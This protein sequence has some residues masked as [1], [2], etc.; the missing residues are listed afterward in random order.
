MLKFKEKAEELETSFPIIGTKEFQRKKLKKAN[1]TE[2]KWYV[3]QLI[4]N[5][6]NFNFL[7]S[8]FDEDFDTIK[9]FTEATEPTEIKKIQKPTLKETE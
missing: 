7:F 1:E 6:K 8:I 2:L 4:Q 9:K 5:P 3:L